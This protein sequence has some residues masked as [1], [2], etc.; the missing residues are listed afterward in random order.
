MKPVVLFLFMV[1]FLPSVVSSQDCALGMGGSDP[2]T[3]IRAFEL[4]EFQQGR[5]QKWIEA[6]EAENAPLQIQLDSLLASHP[7]ETPEQLT[8][9]GQKFEAIKERMVQNSLKYDQLLL[10]VFRPGQYRRYEE[11]CEEV[12]QFPLEP[13]SEATLKEE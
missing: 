8:A 5:M 1:V 7:Q 6:L 2:Q 10:G 11:L 3:I 12:G 9:L 13:L 4:D